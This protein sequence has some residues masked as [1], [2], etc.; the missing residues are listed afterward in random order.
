[1]SSHSF[2]LDHVGRRASECAA[3]AVVNRRRLTRETLV[4]WRQHLRRVEEADVLQRFRVVL[5]LGGRHRPEG[6]VTHRHVL[7]VDVHRLPR[8]IDVALDVRQLA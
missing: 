4:Q 2:R 6:D 1:M 7:D 3:L 8:R 5:D